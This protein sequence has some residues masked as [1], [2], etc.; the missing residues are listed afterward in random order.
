MGT[1]V[2]GGTGMI[3][4]SLKNIAEENLI[5]NA[6]HIKKEIDYIDDENINGLFKHLHV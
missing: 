3:T 6:N 4:N 2:Y 1:Y 5:V